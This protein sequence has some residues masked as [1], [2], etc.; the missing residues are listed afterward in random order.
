[1]PGLC[2]FCDRPLDD[3]L[4]HILQSS[5]G[6]QK[7]SR[8]VICS[9]H[10]NIFGRT[11][12]GVLAKQFALLCNLFAIETGRGE[13]AAT[14]QGL[15]TADGQRIDLAPG[16]KMVARGECKTTDLEPGKKQVTIQ[17]G[18]ENQARRLS[19]QYMKKFG[20]NAV[21]QSPMYEMRIDPVAEVKFDCEIGGDAIR[22]IAKA[23]LLLLASELGADAVRGDDTL[24]VRT[25]ITN[26]GE[27]SDFVRLDYETVCP[28]IQQLE[29][30]PPFAHRMAAIADPTARIAVALIELFGTFR[31]TVLLSADW[32]GAALAI[33]YGVDPTTG[34]DIAVCMEA[35]SPL[36]VEDFRSRLFP[37]TEILPRLERLF[38]M[39][40]QRQIEVSIAEITERVVREMLPPERVG[41][42]ITP[43][44]VAEI[45]KV[46]LARL[47]AAHGGVPY[48]KSLDV[49]RLHEPA[50]DSEPSA[51]KRRRKGQS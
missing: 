1:M 35:H 47:M 10:N 20:E 45:Q 41:T 25:F 16:G 29:P 46:A 26:G 39:A 19:A 40:K 38:A 8:R 12:D 4:E 23:G 18:D 34:D 50:A 24:A 51:R 2:T 42:M 44:E 31:Y 49:S 36:T 3:S 37:S 21:L 11:I 32:E 13:T 15:E 6:G 14:L 33:H 28:R 5:I 43:V 30:L 22:A 9:E 17:A 7:C 48:S 27:S